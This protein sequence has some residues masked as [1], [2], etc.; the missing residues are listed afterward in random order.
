MLCINDCYIKNLHDLLEMLDEIGTDDDAKRQHIIDDVIIAFDNGTLLKWLKEEDNIEE[1]VSGIQKLYATYDPERQNI[2]SILFEAIYATLSKKETKI[3]YNAADYI[4]IHDVYI[5]ANGKRLSERE[6]FFNQNIISK[7]VITIQ[8]V[9]KVIKPLNGIF[10]FTLSCDKEKPTLTRN[11]EVSIVGAG[12]GAIVHSNEVEYLANEQLTSLPAGKFALYLLSDDS[13][14]PFKDSE[15]SLYLMYDFDY[16][17]YPIK[18]L[19]VEL[20]D[21]NNKPIDINTTTRKS[22]INVL[23]L[24]DYSVNAVITYNIC[25][26]KSMDVVLTPN[27]GERKTIHIDKDTK[28]TQHTVTIRIDKLDEREPGEYL[29]EIAQARRDVHK[30]V[31]CLFGGHSSITISE[32]RT[33]QLVSGYRA[34][35]VFYLSKGLF[36]KEAGCP[37]QVMNEI[38]QLN[39][40]FKDCKIEI[41]LPHKQDLILLAEYLDEVPESQ[42]EYIVSIETHFISENERYAVKTRNPEISIKVPFSEICKVGY[43]LKVEMPFPQ[44]KGIETTISTIMTKIGILIN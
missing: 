9:F 16:I 13:F 18:I 4:C 1:I 35:G 37:N 34:S 41:S 21:A 32:D 6:V 40:Q 42:Y 19:S 12:V 26:N 14:T 10:R 28:D 30:I 27:M 23:N 44:T 5:M 33:L 20:R 15:L 3:L 22:V 29:F 11:V 39:K 17:P 43:R 38:E 8:Y 7:Y 2:D 31:L 36:C 25:T 24:P